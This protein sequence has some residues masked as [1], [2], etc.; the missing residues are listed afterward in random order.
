MKILVLNGPNINL[1]GIRD[2]NIYGDKDYNYL[3]DMIVNY[4]ENND[5]DV[6]V[7]QSNHEG[8]LI[9]KI[10][11][12]YLN[13]INGIVINAGGYTHTSV[14]IRDAIDAVNIPTVEVHISDIYSRENFRKLSYIKDVVDKSIVGKGLN[15]YIEAIE[16][17][18]NKNELND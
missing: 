8:D 11:E 3:V 1:L 14:S 12:A 4:C 2:K 15:G 5:L 16:Y 18:K 7:Y 9:D 17:L 10:Q 13:G 6:E